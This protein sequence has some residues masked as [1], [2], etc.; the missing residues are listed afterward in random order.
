MKS[1]NREI[2][3]WNYS[4][5]LKFDRRLGSTE[6]GCLSKCK[7]DRTILNTKSR[8]F[9]ISRDLRDL[10]GIETESSFFFTK[11]FD[12]L[13][14]VA[15]VWSQCVAKPSAT[16]AFIVWRNISHCSKKND[17]NDQSWEM[18]WFKIGLRFP[19]MNSTR[20][21]LS[22]GKIV[23][24]HH[25]MTS[26]NGSIFCITGPLCGEFTGHRWI[27]LTKASDAELW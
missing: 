26:S 12:A 19:R 4:I 27:P 18:I 22:I 20:L 17:F 6:V 5:A 14:Q 8:C 24:A 7:S 3:S 21:C 9:E 2:G 25:M 15:V 11:R 13:F 1:R 23:C 16:M 10:P